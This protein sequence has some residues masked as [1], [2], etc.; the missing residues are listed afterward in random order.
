MELFHALYPLC[1]KISGIHFI[2][3]SDRILIKRFSTISSTVFVIFFSSFSHFRQV[4]DYQ[5]V[6][7]DFDNDRS[8]II[9]ILEYSDHITNE[10]S[11]R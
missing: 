10:M 5:E 6:Y 2:G 11:A 8:I 1:I 3:N 4:P 7:M 9:E